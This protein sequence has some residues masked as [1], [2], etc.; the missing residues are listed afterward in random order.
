MSQPREELLARFRAGLVERVRVTQRLV[1]EFQATS[2]PDSLRQAL[3]ELHTLKGESRML[4]LAELSELAHVLENELGGEQRFSLALAA[5]DAMLG[6]LTDSAETWRLGEALRKLHPAASIVPQ[7]SSALPSPSADD[8]SAQVAGL[9]GNDRK[10]NGRFVQVD[11]EQIDL[12]CE[13]VAELT[14]AF[15]KL[16]TQAETTWG[17]ERRRAAGNARLIDGFE[18]CRALLDQA[19]ST[20]WTL[21]LVPIEPLLQELARGARAAAERQQ[22]LVELRVFA[23]SVQVERDVADQLWDSMLHLVQNAVDHGVELPD[24]RADKPPVATIT[25]SAESI[26]P[27]IVLRVEDDGRG[28]DP[29]ELRRV[30]AERGVVSVDEALELSDEQACQLLFEHG[31][32]TRSETTRTAGRGVGLDVVRQRVE[33]LGGN[34]SMQSHLRH[35]TGFVLTVPSAITKEKLLVV[36]LGGAPYGLPVRVVRAVLSS[37]ALP[38]PGSDSVVRHEAETLPY[39]SLCDALGLPH[40]PEESVVLILELS[41]RRFGAGARRVIGER[42]LI[43][44]PAEKLLRNTGIG[45]SSVLEDG[46]MVLLPELNFVSRALRA[47]L[48]QLVPGAIT[49]EMRR[50]RVLVADDSPVVRELV[51]GILSAAGLVVEQANDGAAALEIILE[52]EPDL[53]VSDVEMPRMNGF[54]LLAEVRRRSQRLPVVMLS[55][56]G[57]VEDRRRATRL[58]ANAYL[59]KTEF[60]GESLLEVVRRFVNLRN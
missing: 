5:F 49:Q 54:D 60:H 26:G 27:S 29:A 19:T 33:S 2:E 3:G 25:L 48:G 17:R 20:A 13:R 53:L 51:T 11:A 16:E 52:R 50:Q 32:S 10:R 21:R 31:F 38:K 59:V 6:A 18:R 22:K 44:R 35:G 37:D 30:A 47:R 23:G 55:T 1:D 41:G 34:V 42:E 45:A 14:A 43:R 15:G 8:A 9:E 57:S 39:R 46:R 7:P 4:G 24:A 36:E 28:V 40:D 56:R 12:L 58:G